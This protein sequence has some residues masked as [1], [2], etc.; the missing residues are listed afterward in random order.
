LTEFGSFRAIRH[1]ALSS[2]P[3]VTRVDFLELV[4]GLDLFLVLGDDDVHM[5][6]YFFS[7]PFTPPKKVIKAIE[8]QH[9]GQLDLAA[10]DFR[11]VF[12]SS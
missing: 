7:S 6:V 12:D 8:F 9:F 1:L 3:W 2:A 11:V 4:F 5:L 10:A